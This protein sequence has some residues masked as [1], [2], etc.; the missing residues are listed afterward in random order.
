MRFQIKTRIF[1]RAADYWL[2]PVCQTLSSALLGS[3][4]WGGESTAAAAH[5]CSLISGSTTC[6]CL[7]NLSYFIGKMGDCED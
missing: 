5:S 2:L 6:Y 4:L 3:C 1:I 7:L